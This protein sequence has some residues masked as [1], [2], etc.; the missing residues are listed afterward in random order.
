[1]YIDKNLQ[2]SK[3]F[4]NRKTKLSFGDSQTVA[5]N[6]LRNKNQQKVYSPATP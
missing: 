4:T 1:M 5:I 2:M 6:I 3:Q